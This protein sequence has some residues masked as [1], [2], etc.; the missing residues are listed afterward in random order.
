M[1]LFRRILAFLIHFNFHDASHAVLKDKVLKDCAS[2]S[3]HS[4][5]DEIAMAIGSLSVED[6]ALRLMWLRSKTSNDLVNVQA[7]KLKEYLFA[8]RD[9]SRVDLNG[10]TGCQKAGSRRHQKEDCGYTREHRPAS[11]TALSPLIGELT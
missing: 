9:F 3:R 2:C 10:T 4:A 7:S 1:C 11:H 8:A 6:E 5:C